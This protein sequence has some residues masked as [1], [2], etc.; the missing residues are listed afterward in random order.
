MRRARQRGFSALELL[1]ALLIT[2]VLTTL[3]V[4]AWHAHAH[5]MERAV[6]MARLQQAARCQ[7]RRLTWSVAATGTPDTS[8]LPR[9]SSTYRFL[10]V[11]T[12]TRG[13]A[14]FE[15]RAEP[16][17][18]QRADSCGTLV[19]DHQGRKSVLGTAEHALRCWQGRQAP[20]D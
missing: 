16:K 4:P 6:A 14:T 13:E 7:A 11:R 18:R 15:W 3:A 10:V 2:G 8:C 19:L 12:D 9:E 5:R 1:T 20:R 17:G